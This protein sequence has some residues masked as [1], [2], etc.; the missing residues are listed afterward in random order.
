MKL[1]VSYGG[2]S[3]SLS[4]LSWILPHYNQKGL[5][6]ATCQ[7]PG[8]QILY[9]GLVG[10]GRGTLVYKETGH[11]ETLTILIGM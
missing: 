4:H 7:F 11:A 1:P 6:A 3:L 9:G 2:S 5:P 8:M 10:L